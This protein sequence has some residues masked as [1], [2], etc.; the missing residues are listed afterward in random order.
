M[1]SSKMKKR[2]ELVIIKMY[3]SYTLKRV[4]LKN[5]VGR[6]KIICS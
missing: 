5:I 6:E 2:V 3:P 1:N 4:T